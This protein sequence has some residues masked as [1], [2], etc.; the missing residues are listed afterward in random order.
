[1]RTGNE[2]SKLLCTSW[3]SL[4]L[5]L[6]YPFFLSPSL[7]LGLAKNGLCIVEYYYMPASSLSTF[8]WLYIDFAQIYL[9]DCL[10]QKKLQYKIKRTATIVC[11]SVSFI[12][13]FLQTK[14]DICVHGKLNNMIS[15]HLIVKF[16]LN[17]KK[18]RI[19]KGYIWLLSAPFLCMWVCNLNHKS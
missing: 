1:M 5:T 8:I 17:W 3:N 4:F 18:V 15:L 19:W 13:A 14:L 2:I 10:E 9:Y 16:K 7:S 11:V 12:C 6:S